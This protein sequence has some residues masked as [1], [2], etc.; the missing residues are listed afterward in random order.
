MMQLVRFKG[1]PSPDGRYF[2]PFTSSQKAREMFDLI[3]R[4]FPLRQC[5]DEEFARRT[6]P[7]LLY[8]IKRCLAPCV[9][10]CS[11]EGYDVNVANAAR[12][13]KGQNHE[14]IAELKKEMQRASDALEFEK[15]HEV[16]KKI[17]LLESF[18]E[19]QKVEAIS[20]A[21]VDVVGLFRE[22]GDA[23]ITILLYR[24]AK[25]VDAL[26]FEFQNIV[27]MDSEL[28][29]SFLLQHYITD[30]TSEILVSHPIEDSGVISEILTR[31]RKKRSRF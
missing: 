24:D 10:L 13:L 7:C 4:T 6:R 28:L 15:A 5:T 22:G 29:Q 18:K 14:L 3:R 23:V 16:L 2:G 12:L 30:A 9:N 31:E 26:H 21:N 20:Q 19:T 17:R 8:Q 11:H 25:L 1:T 27:G